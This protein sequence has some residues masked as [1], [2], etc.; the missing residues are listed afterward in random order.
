LLRILAY[1]ANY[2]VGGQQ[3]LKTGVQKV[4]SREGQLLT[5]VNA[6]STSGHAI[7]IKKLSSALPV[8]RC[9]IAA[10]V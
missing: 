2:E 10:L 9:R 1:D 6:H 5:S 4:R 8:E 3:S 7:S